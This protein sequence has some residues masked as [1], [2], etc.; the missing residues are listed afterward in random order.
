MKYTLA[1]HILPALVLAGTQMVTLSSAHA[2]WYSEL[3]IL[4]IDLDDT[5]LNSTGR[6]VNSTLDEDTGFSSVLGYQFDGGLRLEGEY[7]STGN[8]TKSVNFNGTDFTG[9]NVQG[10]LE[11]ESVF[12]NAIKNFNADSTYSPYVGVGIGYTDVESTIAYDPVA[13]ITDSDKVF[14]YQFL[15]GLDVSLS[16]NLTGF[17][18]YRLLATDDVSLNRDGGGPGGRQITAQQGDIEFDAFAIGLKYHY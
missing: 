2:G 3:S 8:D 6:S 16:D 7:I 13:N 9:S 4:N 5:A 15:T 17:V 11:T 14:S 18:E 1:K 10:G 12:L